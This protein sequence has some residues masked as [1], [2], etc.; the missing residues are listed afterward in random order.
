MCNIFP[1]NRPHFLWVSL[2]NTLTRVVGR[3]QEKLVNHLPPA[4]DLQT[5]QFSSLQD[6]RCNC[7]ILLSFIRHHTFVLPLRD[8]GHAA[9]IAAKMTYDFRFKWLKGNITITILLFKLQLYLYSPSSLC[10]SHLSSF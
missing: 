2:H 7:S 4:C 1:S 8:G 10:L 6:W 5:F 3:T 9:K